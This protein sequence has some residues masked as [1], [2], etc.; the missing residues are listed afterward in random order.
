MLNDLRVAAR[1]LRLAPR[2]VAVAF[3]LLTVGLAAC[4]TV[5]A[6]VDPILLRRLPVT[7]GDRL[8]AIAESTRA[9]A[10]PGAV[11]FQHY[12]EWRTRTDLFVALGAIGS[13][14]LE[15]VDASGPESITAF[16]ATSELLAVLGIAPALGR[17]L[18]PADELPGAE[19]VGL[20]SDAYWR[21]YFASDPTVI[22]R[23]VV[24]GKQNVR[25]V[26]V[27][28][29]DFEYPIGAKQPTQMLLSVQ[30]QEIER[31]LTSP[32][33]VQRWHVVGRLQDRITLELA[34]AE[35]QRTTTKLWT[36]YPAFGRDRR[37]WVLQLSDFLFGSVRPWM[38]ALLASIG[39]L[40]AMVIANVANLL[41]ARGLER[42]QE[43]A[44]RISLGASRL[45]IIRPQIAESLLISIP[46]LGAALLIANW[47]TQIVKQSL[48]MT[49]PRASAIG[50][51][52]RV[53]GI[54]A[55]ITL[56]A[57]LICGLAPILCGD[58]GRVALMKGR[59]TTSVG[60]RRVAHLLL[61]AEAAL[62][63]TLMI[64]SAL[65]VASFVRLLSID[66]GLVSKG[67][68]TFRAEVPAFAGTP[69]EL[70]QAALRHFDTILQRI[71]SMPTVDAVAIAQGGVPFVGGTSRYTATIPGNARPFEGEDAAEGHYVSP[72]Y[73]HLLG[74][75]LLRGRLIDER[76]TTN[77]PPIVILNE[78]A[79]RRYFGTQEPL[80]A[81]I[82]IGT[83]VSTV[84]GVIGNIRK[85]G[86]EDKIRPQVYW[87]FAQ[88]ASSSADVVVRSTATPAAVRTSLASLAPLLRGGETPAVV[89]LD[90]VL[91][92]L[93]AERRFNTAL[94]TA[95]GVLTLMTMLVGVYSVITAIATQ[96]TRDIA[97][98]LVLGAQRRHIA[99]LVVGETVS[100]VARGSIIGI[101]LAW[102]LS[103][104]V[105]AALFQVRP[106]ELQVYAAAVA[107][108]FVISLL[109]AI[110]PAVRTARTEPVA[111]LR[112]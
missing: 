106:Q 41:L 56:L 102:V 39:T 23:V 81:S 47:A 85:A 7:R 86:P 96:R 71:Q 101:G 110:V 26:G 87:P 12:H 84:V 67:I 82:K 22:D 13:S 65:F 62:A 5:L 18:I 8:V 66:L 57:T 11:A 55:V 2:F 91:A 33:R 42:R 14:P 40:L 58:P 46:A 34:A 72:G 19:R 52:W 59:V 61:G 74:I 31:A 16:E 29:P 75:R 70:R 64:G 6:V 36:D 99:R 4:M 37:L 25:I 79:V 45:Q 76:D 68:F 10:R 28:P 24:F 100:V 105:A 108:V 109:G 20:M 49:I 51:D 112:T 92:K 83:G 9:S 97:V 32:G 107:T 3:P 43:I 73:F 27:L 17:P 77:A 94:T 78:E 111:A 95:V 35:L 15:R 30:L 80:G 50:I 53:L 21:R 1:A 98:R 38:L 48:P 63:V 103:R 90:D 54:M 88:R 89:K 69:A 104:L 60:T 44:T 93:T